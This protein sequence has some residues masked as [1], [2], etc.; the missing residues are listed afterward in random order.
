MSDVA[1][2]SVLDLLWEIMDRYVDD[3]QLIASGDPDLMDLAA[4]HE[5]KGRAHAMAVAI[6][7][8]TN[9]YHSD[10][11]EVKAQALERWER[12]GDEPV[13]PVRTRNERTT[14]MT[15]AERA[16]RREQRKARRAARNG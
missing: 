10:V 8:V 12:A 7:R 2:K 5:A 15:D 3:V 11:D 9:P 14:S 6:S 13:K 16:R 4:L 1:G